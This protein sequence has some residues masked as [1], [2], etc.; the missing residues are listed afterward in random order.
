MSNDNHEVFEVITQK[1][2]Q[3]KK[4]NNLSYQDIGDAT[5]VNKSH[6]YRIIKMDTYPSFKFLIRLAQFMDLP[7]Y[8]LFMPSEEFIQQK[9]INKVCRR[10]KEL[11]LQPTGLAE[12]TDISFLRVKDILNKSASPTPEEIKTIYRVLQ[13]EDE[14]NGLH[15]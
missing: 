10:L 8:Y 3:F 12:K 14:S 11:D 15:I 6:I 1:I 7:L 5:G 2:A 13:I 4:E 9:F